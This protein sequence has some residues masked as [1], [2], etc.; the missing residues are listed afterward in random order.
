MLLY[1]SCRYIPAMPLVF[2]WFLD[3]KTSTW[4]LHLEMQQPR[5]LPTVS[6]TTRP[7]TRSSSMYIDTA[8]LHPSN[9]SSLSSL[10][11]TTIAPHLNLNLN[12]TTPLQNPG[13]IS[14]I[15]TFKPG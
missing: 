4:G 1:T 5:R 12:L 2:R 14:T 7:I 8:M 13:R 11:T 6:N 15:K 3:D 10:T 9:K